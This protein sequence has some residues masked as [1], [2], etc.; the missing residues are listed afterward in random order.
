M[1]KTTAYLHRTVLAACVHWLLNIASEFA[2]SV[3]SFSSV[4][5]RRRDAGLKLL[6]LPV[7]YKLYTYIYI[8]MCVCINVN[9]KTLVLFWKSLPHLIDANTTLW[10]GFGK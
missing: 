3:L 8:Y 4:V 2:D 6:Q 1:W 7:G 9:A 5:D 10:S